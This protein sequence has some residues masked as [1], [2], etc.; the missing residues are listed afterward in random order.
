MERFEI[1][2]LIFSGVVA[3]STIVYV[4][5]TIKLTKE[6]RLSREFFLDSHIIT[7]LTIQ[8]TNDHFVDLK[9]KTI[10]KG[11]AR[12]VKLTLLNKFD[13]DFPN[14]EGFLNKG[15]F[16][17]GL[18]YFPPDY[19]ITYLIALKRSNEHR[20]LEIKIEYSDAL[21]KNKI[22]Y[23][24]LKFAELE[25][26]GKMNPPRTFEATISYELSKLN[27]ILKK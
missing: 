25:G 15:L 7:Y 19:E 4:V 23:T 6:T 11:V 12:N 26:I 5:Y 14:S 22:E 8:E 9:I 27:E 2:T 20:T 18:T 10:G 3:I 24:T 16:S 13:A 1:I 21:S 17:S